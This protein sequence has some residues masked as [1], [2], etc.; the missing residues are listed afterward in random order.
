MNTDS[1]VRLAPFK[2]SST[3]GSAENK[4]RTENRHE[5]SK[6]RTVAPQ[7]F[8]VGPECAA[9]ARSIQPNRSTG[10]AFVKRTQGTDGRGTGRLVTKVF[11]ARYEHMLTV[12]VFGQVYKPIGQQWYQ[13][14]GE[15]LACCTAKN[16]MLTAERLLLPASRTPPIG[17]D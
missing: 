14:I 9:P 4:N 13:V 12:S 5:L 3:T 7:K 10:R 16:M 1:S 2:T 6:N 15:Q 11:T 17:P 8:A